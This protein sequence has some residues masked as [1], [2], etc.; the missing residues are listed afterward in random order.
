MACAR[1]YESSKPFYRIGISSIVLTPAAT[2]QGA[3]PVMDAC[4]VAGGHRPP[5][6]A[7][8]GIYVNTTHAKLGDFGSK[9]LPSTPS[10]AS[11]KVGSAVEVSWSIEANHA[12]GCE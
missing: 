12:G 11:W 10:G 4:G 6:G 2:M 7:F 9:T 8:G 1:E 3:A 5:N